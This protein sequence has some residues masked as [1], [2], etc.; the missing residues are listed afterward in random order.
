M[1]NV[2]VKVKEKFNRKELSEGRTFG[3]GFGILKKNSN[4]KYETLHAITACKDYLNDFVFI[5][6]TKKPLSKIHGFK[7]FYTGELVNKRF[8][9]L[10]ISAV[11]KNHTGDGGWKNLVK[12]RDILKTN[13][14]TLIFNINKLEEY[15]GIFSSR[16][17]LKGISKDGNIVLRVP[18]FWSKFPF[19]ISLYTLFLRCVF[20]K[21][22]EFTDLK[23]ELVKHNPFIEQDKYLLQSI[24]SFLKIDKLKKQIINYKIPNLSIPVGE[25][26]NG[27]IVKWVKQINKKP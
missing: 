18:I 12:C 9:Y 24:V 25:I 7:H 13:I 17:S 15:L 6:N 16:T 23:K 22:E 14:K 10:S 2:V 4:K 19:L 11:E 3:I 26:H 20:N 8:F 1:S 21:K 27:G 5:E